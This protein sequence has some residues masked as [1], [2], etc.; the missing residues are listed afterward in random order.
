MIRAMRPLFVLF[1]PVH[2]AMLALGVL[3]PV[4]LAL[5]AALLTR[6]QFAYEL[7]YACFPLRYRRCS[8][9]QVTFNDVR[10]D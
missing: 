2:L 6:K 4:M 9:L 7:G 3:A 5:F 10:D 1:G 8:G